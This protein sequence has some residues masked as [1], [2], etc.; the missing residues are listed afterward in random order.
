M[1]I[2]F[3]SY[4]VY[5]GQKYWSTNELTLEATANSSF[6]C[7]SISQERLKREFVLDN[8]LW[9]LHDKIYHTHK[10]RLTAY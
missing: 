5:V 2:C 4:E 9:K 6:V 7:D 8:N 3:S 10:S 1:I